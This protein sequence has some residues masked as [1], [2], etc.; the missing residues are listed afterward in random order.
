MHKNL[1]G[2]LSGFIFVFIIIVIGNVVIVAQ[3]SVTGT[4]KSEPWSNKN[5]DAHRDAD[6]GDPLDISILKKDENKLQLSFSRNSSGRNR[7]QFGAGFDYSELQGLTREQTQNGK[8]NFRIVREA[9]TL[10][11]DG[12]FTGGKGSGTFRFAPSGSYLDAMRSRGFD[13]EKATTDND[14]GV[15]GKLLNAALINVTTAL[16]DDLNSVNFGK[17]DVEDLF[18]AAIFRIDSKFMAEMKATGFPDLKM[19]D[20]V[21]ARI[22]K[23]DGEYVRQVYGMGFVEKD[24]EAMVKFRIFKVTPEFLRELKATGFGDLSSEDVVKIR[25][26]NI[27]PDFMRRAR[28]T[29]PS[30]SIEDLVQMKIGVYRKNG[31]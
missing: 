9:G 21:K 4:W 16:A 23:I 10:E 26:F 24:F 12:V 27:E 30:V 3:N 7:N 25:I 2:H 20:L 8:V 15:E 13:F 11:C 18:K 28:T 17:L 1:R 29:D 5:S 14:E 6:D 31:N 19:E 22:F